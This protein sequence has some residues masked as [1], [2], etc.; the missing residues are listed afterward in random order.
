MKICIETNEN[1]NMTTQ[2]LWDSVKTVLRRRFNIIQILCNTRETSN[3]QP[4]LTLKVT[5][6]RKK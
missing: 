2:N 1:E 5:R 4:N 6:K 3:K